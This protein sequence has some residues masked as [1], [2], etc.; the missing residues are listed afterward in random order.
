MNRIILMLALLSTTV[1]VLCCKKE[2]PADK[3][4][5]VDFTYSFKNS[6]SLP[7]TIR[8]SSTSMVYD[9][10]LWKFDGVKTSTSPDVR[11]IYTTPGLHKIKLIATNAFGSDSLTKEVNIVL[12]APKATFDII[13]RSPTALPD[14]IKFHS[15]ATRAKSL[16]WKI[17]NVKASTAADVQWIYS[18]LG[19]HTVRLIA[20]NEAGSDSLTKQVT[21]AIDVPKAN[22]TFTVSNSEILPV[23]V[24]CTNTS[25][26]PNATY[27]W[28]FSNGSSATSKNAVTSFNAGGIHG[29]T[30]TVTNAAGSVAVTKEIKISP[31]LQSYTSFNGPVIPL[32]AWEGTNK[33][34]ILSRSNAL[35][36][37]TMFKWLRAMEATYAYYQTCNGREP[38]VNPLYL[39]N[40]RT[41]I[42]D[43]AA[44]CGAGC[45]QLGFTGIELQNT[46]FDVMYNAI[47]NSNQY[48]QAV[49]YEFGRNFWFYFP[50][51]AYKANDPV[52]TGYAV[53][54]RFQAMEAAG[55]TGAPFGT[56]SFPTFQANV[57]GL[58]DT[59]LAT[60]SLN[61][62]NTLGVGQGIPGSG[63]GATDLFASFCFRLK[64]DYGGQAFVQN[65]W[66]KAAL[67]PAAATTQDAV[68]NFFLSACAA[69]NKNLT[70]VFIGWK[71]P[72]SGA[73]QTQAQQY[74]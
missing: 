61:W 67:R 2:D 31:Y 16:V 54:M 65:L 48:D 46:Y 62:A 50:Q 36:R 44:T 18:S 25:T 45:G 26:G 70:T 19:V 10:L 51:L 40:N 29:I 5:K 22:F 35:N 21:V 32:Y 55:V 71:W 41:T 63:L 47:N 30:L 28:T 15:T 11:H 49:F 53:F 3:R 73:A 60:P 58:I 56:S 68:D 64:R 1:L 59:Y 20:T 13:R 17:D 33:V 23:A 42:A 7:D 57:Q 34:M 43:V 39:I 69:A 74:P 27:A 4:P 9:A 37:A 66:K 38:A 12:A 14:T 8:C 72:L 52:V 24:T 6:G